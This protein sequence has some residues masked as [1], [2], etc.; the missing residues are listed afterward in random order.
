MSAAADGKPYG[1]WVYESTDR[2]DA[3]RRFYRDFAKKGGFERVEGVEEVEGTSE[4]IRPDGHQLFVSVGERAGQ[5]YVV[6]TETGSPEHPGVIG[7]EVTS[8]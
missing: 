1:I 6:L 8:E 5:S 7:V 3:V 4:F 2:A